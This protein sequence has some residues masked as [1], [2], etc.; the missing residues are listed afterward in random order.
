MNKHAGL[1]VQGYQPQSDEKIDQVNANK[2]LEERVLR[3]AE[4]IRAT[5]GYDARWASI[6]LTHFQEGFMALN[7]AVFQPGRIALPED[8][9]ETKR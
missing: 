6:A 8:A 2:V 1:P 9:A 5:E 7:R 3:V 4:K